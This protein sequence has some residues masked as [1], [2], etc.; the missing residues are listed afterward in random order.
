MIEW[1]KDHEEFFKWLTIGSAVMFVVSIVVAGFVIVRL[2]E[3]YI[4]RDE[5]PK[6]NL[7]VRILKNVVGWPLI[8]AGLAMLVLPGQGMLIVLVGVMLADFPG[9]L[10]LQHWIITRKKILKTINWLRKKFSKPPLEE[11]EGGSGG[12]RGDRSDEKKE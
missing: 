11:D 3:D 12:R 4:T 7:A 8:L 2:P 6:S 5:A 1:A 9:K 10:R